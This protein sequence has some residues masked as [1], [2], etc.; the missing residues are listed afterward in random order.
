MVATVALL[1]Y[2]AVAEVDEQTKLECLIFAHNKGAMCC[3]VNVSTLSD[4]ATA[5]LFLLHLSYNKDL[6]T[7]DC[8][9]VASGA[10]TSSH[11][12]CCAWRDIIPL[13]EQ[14]TAP[15]RHHTGPGIMRS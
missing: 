10:V 7:A 8:T 3:F 2:P 15:Y 13:E 12:T 14:E 1:H 6:F 11:E 4:K 5:F 9:G